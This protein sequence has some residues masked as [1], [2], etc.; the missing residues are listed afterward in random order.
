MAKGQGEKEMTEAVTEKKSKRARIPPED[1]KPTGRKPALEGHETFADRVGAVLMARRVELQLTQE[2]VAAKTGGLLS[3]SQVSQYE[4]GTEPG[5]GKA[6]LMC[7]ALDVNLE[8]ILPANVK[9]AFAR[10]KRSLNEVSAV[11]GQRQKAE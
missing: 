4:R 9:R 11:L 7:F 2:Q 6:L 1:R 10:A 5:L 8:D 3:G